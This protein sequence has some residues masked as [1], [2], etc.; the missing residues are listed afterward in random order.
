M[1]KKWNRKENKIEREKNTTSQAYNRKKKLK[2]LKRKKENISIHR[3]ITQKS[4]VAVWVVNKHNKCISCQKY[5]LG[6]NWA[7]DLYLFIRTTPA[8]RRVLQLFAN[9][10]K[11]CK[12]DE[13]TPQQFFIWLINCNIMSQLLVAVP[14]FRRYP[15]L[16]LL[17]SPKKIL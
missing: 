15:F 12:K 2:M 6:W 17:P 1:R 10:T 13:C 5:M 11:R 7:D 4:N 9:K 3:N 14:K 16:L 8:P